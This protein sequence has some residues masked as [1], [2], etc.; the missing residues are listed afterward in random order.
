MMEL[1]ER[2]KYLRK[3]VLDMSQDEFGTALGVNRDVINNI[4]RNRLKKPEQ[5]EPLYQLICTKF[6]INEEWLRNETPPM[7]KSD[8]IDEYSEIATLIGEK[9]QKAKQAIMDY[10]KLTDADKKLFWNFV[11]KFILKKED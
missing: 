11:D 9:D 2:I 4:E 6:G 7:K 3:E 1:Y 8:I 10:W 5:K